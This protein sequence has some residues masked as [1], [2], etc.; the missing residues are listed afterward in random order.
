MP[1][2]REFDFFSGKFPTFRKRNLFEVL[3]HMPYDGIDL[4]SQILVYDPERRITGKA[5]LKH[6]FLR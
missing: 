3:P 5:A 6:E 1:G 2:M 4:L